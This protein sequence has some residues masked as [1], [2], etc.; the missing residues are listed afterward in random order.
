MN[1]QH[2]YPDSDDS[3]SGD[4]RNFGAGR[5]KPIGA[6]LHTTSGTSSLAWLLA[7][8][9]RAGTPASADFLIDRDGHRH[10]LCR[11]GYYPYHAGQSTA[12]IQGRRF[13]GDQISAVLLGIEM[14]QVGEQEVTYEQFD[15]CAELIVI[16][17]LTYGW[18]WPYTLMGHYE[19]ARPVGRRSDPQGFQWGDFMGRLLARARSAQVPG[20]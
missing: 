18:R 17:G 20:L 16:S 6:L 7:G 15:S 5:G 8:S 19:V 13:Q 14:E 3:N 12:I 2:D 9:A 4:T 10:A 1:G 11:K